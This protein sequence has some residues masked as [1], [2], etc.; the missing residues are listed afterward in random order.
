MAVCKAQHAAQSVASAV[1]LLHIPRFLHDDEALL[2]LQ[3]KR[4]QAAINS[5]GKYLYL[6]SYDT[7]EEAARVS[8]EARWCAGACHA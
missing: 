1:Q 5:S 8:E 2:C 4:W 6:G 3:N 7:E